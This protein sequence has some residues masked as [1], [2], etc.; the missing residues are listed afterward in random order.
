MKQTGRDLLAGFGAIAAVLVIAIRAVIVGSDLRLL[1]AIS[2][3]AFFVA[4]FL[5]GNHGGHAWVRG[6]ITSSPGLLGTAALIV[7]D[8]LHRWPIPLMIAVVSIVSA[9]VGVQMRRTRSVPL[10]V[11]AVIAIP[12]IAMFFV[13]ALVAFSSGDTTIRAT[14]PFAIRTAAGQLISSDALRGRVVVMATWATWCMPCGWELPEIDRAYR[15]YQTDPRVMFI[16]LNRAETP[17]RAKRYL[18]KTGIILPLA[19]ED[20]GFGPGALPKLVILDQQGQTRFVHYGY[21]ASEHVDDVVAKNVSEL[22][23]K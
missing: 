14:R 15:R 3:I 23:A 20:S 22:L 9:I 16:A 21:D 17:D 5:R 6:L 1:F 12:L 8:G 10:G 4:G 11:G 7:N 19:F 2:M 18:S 13:P